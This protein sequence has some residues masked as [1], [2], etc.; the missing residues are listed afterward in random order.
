VNLHPN[1][2]LYFAGN[3][4]AGLEK[5][6]ADSFSMSSVA[7]PE[8]GNSAF[9]GKVQYLLIRA[10]DGKASRD[11]LPVFFDWAVQRRTVAMK[12]SLG[13]E[14]SPHFDTNTFYVGAAYL[15]TRADQT[16]PF[17]M[18]LAGSFE[19]LTI[20]DATVAAYRQIG[21]DDNLPDL[22]RGFATKVSL[23]YNDFGFEFG[24]TKL[25]GRGG[26]SVPGLTGG[27]FHIA[28]TAAGRLLD[29]R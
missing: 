23:Q 9:I 14:S 20:F 4:G 28:F 19:Q 5:I 7:F 25:R 11:E 27:L 16:S 15:R 21:G 22:M 10:P 6:Q 8:E 18:T 29:V 1:L 12:D 26:K 17:R 3:K 2:Q 24:Y 13:H